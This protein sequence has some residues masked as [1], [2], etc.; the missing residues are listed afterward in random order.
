M[1][2]KECYDPSTYDIYNTIIEE[3]LEIIE[4]HY[5][6]KIARI[7]GNMLDYDYTERMNP[8]TLSIWINR[9]LASEK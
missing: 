6:E 2:S 9:E 8:K 3:R 7:I 5:N 4:G 1:P